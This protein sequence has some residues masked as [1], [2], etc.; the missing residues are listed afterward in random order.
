[1]SAGGPVR[2]AQPSPG[3]APRQTPQGGI[4]SIAALRH[5]RSD[6]RYDVHDVGKR[7]RELRTGR[8]YSVN[9][10]ARLAGVPA[11]T[12]SKIENG[13]LRPSLVHAINLAAALGENLG[14]LVDRYRGAP[15]DEVIV[16]AQERDQIAY[17]EIGMRLQD[18]NGNFHPGLLEARVGQLQ[19]HAHSGEDF[20]THPGE[21]ICHVLQ[22]SLRF[23]F[24]TQTYDLERGESIHFKSTLKHRWENPSDRPAEVLWVFSD[25]LSF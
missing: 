24:E 6:A 9:R 20:M 25:G 3:V 10:L 22:G 11:S 4:S 2:S 14:F 12:I 13:L 21:E 15:Q 5:T 19:P 16:R 1:M 7:L 23:R 18:L 8:N 17:P